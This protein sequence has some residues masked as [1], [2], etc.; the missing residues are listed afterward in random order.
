MHASDLS[1]AAWRKSSYSNGTGGSCVEITPL[2]R[3]PGAAGHAVAVRDS[4]NPDGPI[5][6]FTQGAWRDFMAQ[7][8]AGKLDLP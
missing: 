8:K 6:A 5:L 4:K 2:S 1:R 7:L 3:Q